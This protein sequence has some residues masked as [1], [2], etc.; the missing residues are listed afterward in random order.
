MK[1]LLLGGLVFAFGFLLAVILIGVPISVRAGAG[2]VAT[3][4]GDVNGDGMIDVSDAVYTLLYLFK[5]GD[6]PVA[7]ADTPELVARVDALETKLFTVEENATATQEEL[8]WL[9]EQVAQATDD[10]LVLASGPPEGMLAAI[11]DG[12][13]Q[14]PEGK[15]Y[16]P[17]Y[18]RLDPR[19]VLKKGELIDATLEG[20]WTRGPAIRFETNREADLLIEIDGN[21]A[22]SSWINLELDGQSIIEGQIGGNGIPYLSATHYVA[23]TVPPGL[24]TLTVIGACQCGGCLPRLEFQYFAVRYLN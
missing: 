20:S 13:L 22:G 21:V 2:S 9:R 23:F 17:G 12:A 11:V 7:C 24:H 1:N 3:E 6:P 18:F 8:G 16:G 10:V 15:S 5:G 14:C 4:N 19:V